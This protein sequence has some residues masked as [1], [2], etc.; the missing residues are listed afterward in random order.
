MERVLADARRGPDVLGDPAAR[1]LVVVGQRR[2]VLLHPDAQRRL[3]HDAG[4]DAA[5][6]LVPPAHRLLQKA[7]R[8]AGHAVVRK[9]VRPRPDQALLRALQAREQARDRVR[10]AVRPAADRIDRAADGAVVLADRAVLPVVVAPLVLHPERRERHEIVD[11]L[12]PHRAPAI[13]DDLRIGRI[14]A[15]IEQ[16]RAPLHV[17]VQQ[18]AAH[19]VG[20]VGIAV[21]GR[22]QRD[23]RLQ[24]LRGE[25]CDLERVEAAPGDAHHADRPRAPGLRGDPGDDL[26]RVLVLL[27]GVFVAQHAVGIARAAHVDAHRGIAVAGKIAVDRLVAAAREVALAVGDALQDGRHR[28]ASRRAR[29]PDAGRDPAA[30][31]H[32]DP[33]VL[34]LLDVADRADRLH[35]RALTP[36]PGVEIRYSPGAG[37]AK[38]GARRTPV[39]GRSGRTG[40]QAE[41][42]M[43][44]GSHQL[45]PPRRRL[46]GD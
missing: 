40:L 13:A 30:V 36:S 23:D 7:D 39:Q 10:V 17:L 32:R 43:G 24:R 46:A 21:V 41:L 22:A 31:R 20:V 15:V 19:V 44:A 9:E 3:V 11:P 28:L 35:A 38:A 33:D 14:G 25:G 18:A 34:D 2:H 16:D 12:A 6:P 29:Q 26:E 4:V 45:Q 27:P 8:R 1:A 37:A 5:Q 42:T